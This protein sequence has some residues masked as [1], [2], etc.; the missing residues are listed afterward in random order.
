VFPEENLSGRAKHNGPGFVTNLKDGDGD[1][2]AIS[3]G[4]LHI[5]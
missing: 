1:A 4:I 3:S 2:P 5:E